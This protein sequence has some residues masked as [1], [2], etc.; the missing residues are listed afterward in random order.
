MRIAKNVASWIFIKCTMKTMKHFL[1][2]THTM[3]RSK[4]QGILR[5]NPIFLDMIQSPGYY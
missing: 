3:T 5:L 2:E 1:I 4:K